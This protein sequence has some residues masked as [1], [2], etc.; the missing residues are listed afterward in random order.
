MNN[1]IDPLLEAGIPSFDFPDNY[2]SLSD[3]GSYYIIGY[4]APVSS[5]ES[6]VILNIP[7]TYNGKPVKEISDYAF[8]N[9]NRKIVSIY[10][11]DSICKIGI[12]FAVETEKLVSIIVDKNNKYFKSEG[13]CLIEIS[14][15]KLIK[16]TNISVIP[17]YVNIIGRHS[18]NG[19][20]DLSSVVIPNSV[21]KIDVGAF[22]A[23][24]L[25]SINIP[26][27]VTE[28]GESAFWCC[29][30]IESISIPSSVVTLGSWAFYGCE[31]LV[32]III[33]ESVINIGAECFTSCTNL[34]N[35]I[36][37]CSSNAFNK[38]K[39]NGCP[40]IEVIYVIEGKGWNKEDVISSSDGDKSIEIL[41][42]KASLVVKKVK[43]KS[44]KI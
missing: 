15:N 29:E 14:T 32:S 10:I 21:S 43:V 17:D 7:S 34:K 27:S 38:Y 18:F 11:P 42:S 8:C 1:T 16:G 36:L 28:I 5:Q 9:L 24:G 19:C 30:N 12:E 40:N 26:E 6:D 4:P 2:F 35:V 3:D 41:P 37:K 44:F 31:N 22:S 13:N 39:F 33:P 20:C 23:S 25:K